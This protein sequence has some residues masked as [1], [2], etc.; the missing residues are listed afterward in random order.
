MQP[1]ERKILFLLA[2]LNFTHILDFMI[3]MPL[4]NLLMPYFDIGASKFS[5]LVAAYAFSAGISSFVAAFYVNNYDR[6]K[7]LITSYIGFLVGTL[8][9]G[10]VR[11]YYL[12]MGARIIAGLFGGLIGAQVIAIISDIVPWERRGMGMGIVMSSFSVA[13]I[14]G[15]P[16]SLYMANT[17]GWYM[18]F[19]LVAAMGGI[20]V[21]LL[22]YILPTMKNHIGTEVVSA[23]ATFDSVMRNRNQWSALVFSGLMMTGH[24][25]I[26]PFIN[27]YLEFNMGYSKNITP[28]VYAV[29]GVSSLIS[30]YAIGRL[31][32]KIGK[33]KTLVICVCCSI[34]LIITICNLPDWHPYMTLVVFGVWFFMA[35]GRGVSAQALISNVA[36]PEVRGSFQ[37][38]NSFMQQLGTG[39]ASIISGLVVLKTADGSLSG[40]ANLG[41]ISIIILLLSL[42]VGYQPFHKADEALQQ[43]PR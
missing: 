11:D 28:M 33:W 30:A 32:D 4:G 43:S 29:G 40:Y 18:P 5:I 3:M 36:S 41:W 23:R 20:L 13:S 6:K 14:L 24:F 7:I 38:F 27:P 8:I 19:I 10:L 15:M 22:I 17:Y 42:V 16:L 39:A 37:S 34:P 1:Q 9:C 35:T 21:P 12:L 26:I 2:A 25:M 31:T